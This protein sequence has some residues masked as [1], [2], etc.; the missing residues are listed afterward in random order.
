MVAVRDR[1]LSRSAY[2][3]DIDVPI[4]KT[5]AS[6]AEAHRRLERGGGVGKIIPE[7]GLD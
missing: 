2:S 6:A 3:H 1:I 5:L 7:A 4:A